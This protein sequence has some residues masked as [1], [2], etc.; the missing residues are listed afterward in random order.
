MDAL[1]VVRAVMI[2]LSRASIAADMQARSTLEAAEVLDELDEDEL[3]EELCANAG[4]ANV[5]L[6]RNAAVVAANFLMK[7]GRKI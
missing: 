1:N 6:I 3:E 5:A 4:I 7:K 2:A